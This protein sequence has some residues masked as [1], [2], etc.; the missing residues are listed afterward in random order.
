[1]VWSVQTTWIESNFPTFYLN[2]L[3]SY[4]KIL[5]ALNFW[6]PVIIRHPFRLVIMAL[7]I[8]RTYFLFDE[9]WLKKICLTFGVIPT[10]LKM[11]GGRKNSAIIITLFQASPSEY[12]L[13]NTRND[14]RVVWFLK[15]WQRQDNML[16]LAK[17]RI[18]NVYKVPTLSL[19]GWCGRSA[20]FRIIESWNTCAM[21]HFSI[22]V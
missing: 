1:M 14:Q 17:V 7:V 19:L 2:I 9:P 18:F 6:L 5:E 10:P 16:P 4:V 3:K 22:S 11:W 20:V 15:E 13:N 12:I 8:G 21:H